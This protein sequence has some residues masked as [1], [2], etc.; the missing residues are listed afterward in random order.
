MKR[1]CLIVVITLLIVVAGC[2]CAKKQSADDLIIVDVT[3]S[4]PKK[5]L[6][7]QYFM[8]VEYVP[9]ETNDEFVTQGRVLAIGIDIIIVRNRFRD[10]D[11]FI[12]DRKNGTGLRKINRRGQGGEEYGAVQTIYLDEDENEMFV[13]DAYDSGKILVYDL[14]GNFKRSFK[15]KEGFL[16]EFFYAY[17]RDNLICN[18]YRIFIDEKRK[19]ETFFIFSKQDGSIVKQIEIPY[20][21]QKLA[22]LR[23]GGM[24]ISALFFPVI[25]HNGNWILTSPSSDTIFSYLPDHTMTPFIVRT[26]SIHSMTPE[27]FLFPGVFTNRYYFMESQKMEYDPTID[28]PSLPKKLMYDSHEKMVYEYTVFNNDFNGKTVDMTKR[29]VNDEVAFWDILEAYQLVEAYEKGQLQGRLKEIAAEMDEE[30]NP[31]IM[32]AKHKNSD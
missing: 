21:Q 1:T 25:K 13:N 27:V 30:D 14:Y 17:D 28:S 3:K 10:G 9:L 15:Q 26:P 2:G 32:I 5:E 4:Y 18:D 31:V 29:P 16:Y 6:I 20:Q 11:I 12:F 7:L 22:K 19:N 24:S 23:V 8:E